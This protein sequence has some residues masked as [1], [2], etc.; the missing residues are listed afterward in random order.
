MTQ[1]ARRVAYED[2]PHYLMCLREYIIPGVVFVAMV[3]YLAV[4][5][6]APMRRIVRPTR[7]SAE[8]VV[9][10]QDGGE[11]ASSDGTATTPEAAGTAEKKNA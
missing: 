11:D 5:V 1:P 9:A 7:R 4:H 3:Y 6:L 8:E 10:A 2:E